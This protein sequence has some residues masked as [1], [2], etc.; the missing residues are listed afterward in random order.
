VN[1]LTERGGLQNEIRLGHNKIEQ[2]EQR[3][4]EQ[5]IGKMQGDLITTITVFVDWS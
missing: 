1:N 5:S 3:E 2:K 4:E